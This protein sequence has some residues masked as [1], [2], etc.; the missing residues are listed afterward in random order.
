MYSGTTIYIQSFIKTGAGIRKLIG[1]YTDAQT[2]GYLLA[3]F[4]FSEKGT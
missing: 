3:Y 2:A 1:G 4:I